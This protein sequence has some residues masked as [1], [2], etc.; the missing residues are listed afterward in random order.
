MSNDLKERLIQAFHS[1][2]WQG[3]RYARI[4][5]ARKQAEEVLGAAIPAGNPLTKTVDEA[6]EAAIVRVAPLLISQASTTHQAYDQLVDLLN[7]QPHIGSP[8]VHLRSPAGLQ[9]PNPDRLPCFHSRW[10]QPEYHGL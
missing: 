10:H 4:H 2:L 3:E 6:M 5:Q 9:H 1:S 7:R 8:I